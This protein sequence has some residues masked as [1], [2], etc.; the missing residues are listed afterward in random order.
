MDCRRDLIQANKANR[1]G[2]LIVETFLSEAYLMRNAANTPNASEI[3]MERLRNCNLMW[4]Y[5][6]NFTSEQ[7]EALMI[8]TMD[9][10]DFTNG[11]VFDTACVNEILYGLDKLGPRQESDTEYMA[12]VAH[13]V[14]NGLYNKKSRRNFLDPEYDLYLSDPI[15]LFTSMIKPYGLM[16][17]KNNTMTSLG[18]RFKVPILRHGILN[19]VDN[20]AFYIPSESTIHY[21]RLVDGTHA[22]K[23]L[24]VFCVIGPSPEVI[25]GPDVGEYGSTDFKINP[26][27]KLNT[28]MRVVNKKDS[29]LY[30]N[31]VQAAVA[32][33]K[34]VDQKYTVGFYIGK[35]SETIESVLDDLQ[36][37]CLTNTQCHGLKPKSYRSVAAIKLGFVHNETGNQTV[38]NNYVLSETETKMRVVEFIPAPRWRVRKIAYENRLTTTEAHAALLAPESVNDFEVAGENSFTLDR[39]LEILEEDELSNEDLF[40]QEMAETN[41]DC[42]KRRCLSSGKGY[43]ME[44]EE[45]KQPKMTVEMEMN[46]KPV[47]TASAAPLTNKYAVDLT[48][49]SAPGFDAR[50]SGGGKTTKRSAKKATTDVTANRDLLMK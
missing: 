17:D 37:R 11:K 40:A 43:M 49:F 45:V 47:K 2:N 34:V 23:Q 44:K 33:I 10:G 21:S 6:D 50:P 38:F 9:S 26:G 27:P 5:T 35:E 4:E 32:N 7:R 3:I 20:G 30:K 14:F 24:P 12:P 31:N 25:F 15:D 39:D 13:T 28:R 1:I 18:N 36:A 41:Y 46:N 22:G 16:L 29:P 19:G 8:A 42:D 48:N